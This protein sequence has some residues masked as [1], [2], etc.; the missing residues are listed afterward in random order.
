MK[1][2]G[3]NVEVFLFL[4]SLTLFASCNNDALTSRIAE[5]EEENGTLKSKIDDLE[6]TNNQL[7]EKIAEIEYE[8]D[9]LGSSIDDLQHS[10]NKLKTEV[11][12]FDYDDWEFNVYEVQNGMYELESEFDNVASQYSILEI[13]VKY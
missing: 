2:T 10:I 6:N 9:E 3:L 1:K 8:T 11:Q 13:T 12:D 4:L 5:L 7:Q